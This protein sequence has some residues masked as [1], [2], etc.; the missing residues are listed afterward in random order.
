MLTDST[1]RSIR[2]LF[3]L[4]PA[5]LAAIAIM[6]PVLGLPATQVAKIGAFVG[7]LTLALTKLRNALED[8]GYIPA[9][10]KAPASDGVDPLPDPPAQT[11]VAPPLGWPTPV[12]PA[13]P[14][15][16]VTYTYP[17]ASGSTVLPVT[18]APDPMVTAPMQDG[19]DESAVPPKVPV[20]PALP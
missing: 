6:V 2:G 10:L 11:P 7:A 15:P 9:V 16:A 13:A 20:S 18:P 1:R 17:T 12:Q 4:I 14:Q 19:E 3:D 8:A 5:I